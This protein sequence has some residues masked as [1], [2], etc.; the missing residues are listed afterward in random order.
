[1]KQQQDEIMSHSGDSV[2]VQ[3]T[4][5]DMPNG[6]DDAVSCSMALCLYVIKI[7][8]IFF[9]LPFNIVYVVFV[10]L[11][12]VAALAADDGAASLPFWPVAHFVC[13]KRPVGA[14]KSLC[15]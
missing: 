1:M 4:H 14:R 5:T 8:Y 11:Q 7:V 9:F 6:M 2:S 12:A 10:C 13:S 15:K 3:H